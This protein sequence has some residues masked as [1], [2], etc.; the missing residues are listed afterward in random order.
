MCRKYQGWRSG[1]ASVLA[2]GT[3]QYLGAA[4]QQAEPKCV[5]GVSPVPPTKSRR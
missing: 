1:L 2:P 5:I 4:N 3:G